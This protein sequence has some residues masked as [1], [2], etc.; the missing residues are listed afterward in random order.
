MASTGRNTTF[1]LLIMLSIVVF[2]FLNMVLGSVRIPM[3]AVWHIFTGTGD[4]PQT[5]Q[6]IIWKSRFPQALTALVAGAGLSISGL[7]MQ[8]VFR[9]PLAG[10]SVLGIS[11]GAS[12][13]VAF[14]VLFSG[15]IGGVALSHLG[16]FGEVA[17]SIAAVA[18]SLSVMALIV[19]ASHKVKGNVTLLIIGVMIG[20]LANAIIGILKFFSVEEDIK[21]YVIWGLGSFSR[22]SG[23]QMMLFVTIMAILIPLSF[24]LV[25]TLN[26]LMLG[27]GY[28]RN[29]G[30][31]IK[32][33]RVLVITCSGV[34]TAIVTAYCGP[35]IFLG[36]A[37]PHLCRAVFQT[38]DHRLLMPACLVMGASLALACN[39]I[40]RMPGFEGALPV[41]SVTALIGAPVVAS[42][43]FR[44]RKN[45]MKKIFTLLCIC[46]LGFGAMAQ[47]PINLGVHGGISSNRIKFK[48]IPQAI[49]TQANTGY[50]VGAFMRVNLGK[51]YL[52][53]ALNYSHKRSVIEEKA[54]ALGEN[55]DNFDLKLNTFDIPIMLGFQVLDLS[56]VKLRA[57]LGPVL[58]VGKVKNLKKLGDIS[59]DKTNWHGKVGVGVDVW[60][61]TFDIDYEK[62]FKN[63]GHELKAPRSFNFT[64]GLK[65]I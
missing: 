54:Q 10:P 43:L 27:D 24:L 25:K 7:Q 59:T 4:E 13:G 21:T 35:I 53:P 29:L 51:L 41:N 55:P 46:C 64:L 36:L 49:G 45:E 50:M 16:L 28:A 2:L 15:S 40:A 33:A 11:S 65:I 3:S 5:W 34:L 63:L 52:E 18:G 47:L 23:N 9:N 20:Y 31:N 17:L 44:K 39:L 42:G 62:A 26:L 32:R 38:S 12:M 57:F 1:I 8:T 56:I 48:D 37:V 22:V 30:L 61:L 14:V 6:N 58:S 60:K 19:F